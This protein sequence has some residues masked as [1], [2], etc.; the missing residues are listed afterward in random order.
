MRR[1]F[2]SWKEYEWTLYE[3]VHQG[4]LGSKKEVFWKLHAY[5]FLMEKQ[6]S[7][8]WRGEYTINLPWAPS[9][10]RRFFPNEFNDVVIC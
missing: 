6:L 10:R 5:A 8:L 2:F 9:V 1:S 4:K 3:F 7:V